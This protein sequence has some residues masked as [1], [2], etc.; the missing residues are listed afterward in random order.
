MTGLVRV[1]L[2]LALVAGA[3]LALAGIWV[4]G[5]LGLA[6]VCVGILAGLLFVAALA[7][8]TL[9]HRSPARTGVTR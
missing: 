8:R 7:V 5:W 9:A 3:W 4:E 6:A 2:P 1:I